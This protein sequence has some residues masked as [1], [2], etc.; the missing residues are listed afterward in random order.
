MSNVLSDPIFH[1]E[2]KAREWVEK[3]VWANGVV[4]PHCG[5]A[6]QERLAV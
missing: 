6:D 3:Q 4:C 2:T 5:N 1:D